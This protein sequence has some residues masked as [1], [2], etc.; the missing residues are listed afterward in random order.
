MTDE[1][2]SIPGVATAQEF[3]ASA[4]PSSRWTRT[5][6]LSRLLHSRFRRD[7]AGTFVAQAGILGLGAVTG[8]LAA[9]MLGPQGRGELTALSIWPM[10]LI[11]LCSM[12]LDAALVFHVGKQQFKL[13]EVWTAGVVLGALQTV[14]VVLVGLVVLPLALRGY[15]A[16][17]RHL[18]FVFLAFAPVFMVGGQSLAIFRGQVKMTAYNTVRTIA[19]AVYAA[20]LVTLFLLR[21]HSLSAVVGCQLAGVAL[22]VAVGYTLL[23]RWDT[24]RFVWNTGALKG[25][26]SFGWK[27]QLSNVT[28]F[29]NQRIDQLLLSLFIPPHDLGLYVVA[30]TVTSGMGIFP[31][32]AGTVTFAS[33]AS[34]KP[35]DAARIISRSLQASL[36]WLGAGA[37]VLFAVVPWAIPWVFG[38]PFAGSVL[39]CRVLLPGTVAL[40]LNQVLYD[41]ARAL[42]QP[43][44]PSYSEGSSLI[45]TAG[46][47][48]LL[49]PR[50]G[51]LG[52][53]I[54]STLAYTVSFIVTLALFKSRAGIGPR[55]LLGLART[56]ESRGLSG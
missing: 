28:A 13:T 5:F 21:W 4:I 16:G 36:L 50:I 33:G 1:R 25:L 53:A 2:K 34:M 8:V 49:V 20:G 24:L 43:A 6:G 52:A 38:R 11:F 12:G 45:I 18:S 9:R 39:A 40:G 23:C 51:F 44:L 41:G 35:Q 48:Y 56:P 17:V 19:P 42:N 32:A 15:S 30:V 10:T 22:L 14:A 29:V 47:L 37:I 7:L 27:T 55:Q 26:V 31:A 54:A 3:A 46:C